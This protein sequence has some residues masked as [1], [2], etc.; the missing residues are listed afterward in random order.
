MYIGA[1]DAI[2]LLVVFALIVLALRKKV[3]VGVTLVGAGLV[4]ALLYQVPV[5]ALLQGYW[6]L[7]CSTRFIFLT[8]VIVLITT[9][10]QL[11]AELRALD[12]LTETAKGL[13]G[14]TKTAVAVL[15][16]LIGLM[17]M[18]GG[19]LLSAPLVGNVLADKKYTPEFRTAS[20]YWFRH[21]VEFAWPIYPGL[22]LTEAIT[23][24]PIG[25]VALVQSPLAVLMAVIGLAFYT[26]RIQNESRRDGHLWRSLANIV[27]TIW[28]IPLAIGLYGVF[29]LDLALSVLVAVVA[30]V[31]VARPSRPQLLAAV[32]KG[33]SYK[34]VFLV[35][36][37]LSFQ[38]VLE[39]T[40][41]I[42]A[43]PALTARY[44]LPPEIVIF[45]VGFTAGILTG[46]VAAF[47]ATAYPILA[48][49]LY[50]PVASPEYIFLAYLAGYL[51]MILSPTHLCLI[52]T[53]DYFQSDLFK[54]Y[55]LIAWP[56]ALMAVFGYLIYLSPWGA[57]FVG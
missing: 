3:S 22:I 53:N 10:G 27:L 44:S 41:A 14:G 28:P 31:A 17:P 16:P 37:A 43:L 40:G 45:V 24:Y 48:A 29:K 5:M 21:V 7:I 18:P 52:L 33:F 2:R 12:R 35:F 54:V 51:G 30:L 57:L 1:M 4:T 36:G 25:R 32:R 19:S 34:L 23:G 13:P 49:F 38:T 6:A 47:V 55:R 50:Q 11:L 42:A 46:M 9:M 20:N 39:L 56:V 15:P 26:T 8:M